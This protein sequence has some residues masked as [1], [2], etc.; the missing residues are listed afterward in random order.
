MGQHTLVP[1]AGEV[2][3]HEVRAVGPA[4]LVMVLRSAGEERRCPAC[5]ETS[6]R[7]TADIP[8]DRMSRVRKNIKRE[9]ASMLHTAFRIEAVR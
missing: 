8:V 3:L 7:L 6:R 5:A 4:R 1:D 2:V 9:H